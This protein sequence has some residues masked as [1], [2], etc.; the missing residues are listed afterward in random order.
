[1]A[2]SVAKVSGSM[3]FTGGGRDTC[4]VTGVLPALPAGFNPAGLAMRIDIGGAQVDFTLDA[5]GR[6][7]NDN[8]SVMLRLKPS[9]RNATTNQAEFTGGDVTF[10]AK[11]TGGTWADDWADEGADPAA[12]ATSTP[13]TLKVQVT[14]NGTLYVSD[15]Q[16]TYSAKAGSAG[17]FKN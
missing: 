5:K 7:R 14:L 1:V 13:M 15:V 2:M 8:G 3:K 9:V 10:T 17:K 12:N 6:A 11:L 4:S 16:T